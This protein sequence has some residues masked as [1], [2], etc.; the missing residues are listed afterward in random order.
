MMAVR[1]PHVAE[2]LRQGG[3]RDRLRPLA[4]HVPF[5][6]EAYRFA[7]DPRRELL[8]LR[9][10]GTSL[11]TWRHVRSL[12]PPVDRL[13]VLVSLFRD[14]VFDTKMLAIVGTALR[15]RRV[16][17]VFKLPSRRATRARRFLTYLNLGK[18]IYDED[19]T[20]PPERRERI[21]ALAEEWRSTCH[22]FADWAR[23]RYG[24]FSPGVL[25]LSTVIR[26]TE[27]G[28]PD[29]TD[30]QFYDRVMRHVQPT[31]IA[32]ERGEAAL[33]SVQPS[34]I[35]VQEPG[36][37]VCGPLVDVATSRGV[38]VAHITTSWRDDA[39]LL[40]GLTAARR[41]ALPQT[42]ERETLEAEL[43]AWAPASDAAVEKAFEQR[44][45]GTWAQQRMFQAGTGPAPSESLRRHFGIP[46]NAPLAVVFAHVLWDATF[47][48]G[49]D[50]YRDYA[51]WL[52]A[53]VRCAAS[54][55]HVHWLVKAHPANV[56]RHS[57]GDV[58]ERCAELRLLE[59][60][61]GRLP[62]H[63]R[64]IPPDTS[65][66]SLQ[67]YR[68]ADYGLTVR[69]SPGFEMACFG[70]PVLTAGTGTYIG[71][72]FTH[73]SDSTEA[74]EQRLAQLHHLPPNPSEWTRRA[75]AYALALFERRPWRLR[76]FQ[77]SFDHEQKRHG[78]E[79]NI[80]PL[81]GSVDALLAA[82]D[83]KSMATWLLESD[84]VDYTETAPAR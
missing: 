62:A 43:Q 11:H 51:A 33:E 48:A 1:R 14:N 25:V 42:V 4:A 45:G 28:H 50:L 6:V 21:R 58:R 55:P 20:V 5:A 37:D 35:V 9:D 15:A 26:E 39:L 76:T 83:L 84:A 16:P 77:P 22:G 79:R 57:V 64:I 31:L 72:G 54:N 44:Y 53:T 32:Y 17:V 71:L 3:V 73:D 65:F 2:L 38:R 59:S 68:E 78:L 70:K 8:H 23:L 10:L 27:N 29:D 75:R 60:E 80:H 40:K 36:Y 67:V 41:R 46:E 18:L 52:L 19:F 81:V 7:L 74:Y 24:E 82:G 61:L 34:A 66:T 47:W 49:D 63:V 13:P 56:H 30:A 69:G 12:P